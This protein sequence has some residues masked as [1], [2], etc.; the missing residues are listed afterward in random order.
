MLQRMT[1]RPG[2]RTSGRTL[3]VRFRRAGQ[4]ESI[5]NAEHLQQTAGNQVVQRLLRS[6]AIQ[7]KLAV[8][9][10]GDA[11]ECE[12]DRVAGE[13]L[14]MPDPQP[15]PTAQRSPLDIQRKCTK[16]EEKLREQPVSD[17]KEK[18]VHAKWADTS[19]SSGVSGG[20]ESYLNTARGGGQP[21]AARER[22]YFEPRFG[23]EFGNVRVHTNSGAAHA[24]DQIRARA[25]TSGDDIVFGARHYAPE[26]NEG[27]KLL[28]HELSHVVQQTGTAALQRKVDEDSFARLG[29]KIEEVGDRR[30][31]RGHEA[32]ILDRAVIERKIQDHLSS[33][34]FKGDERLEACFD[35]RARLRVGDSGASVEKVQNALIDLGFDLGLAGADG[36]YGPRTAEAVKAFKRQEGLG[37]EQFGDVGPGTMRRLDRIF[38]EETSEPGGDVVTKPLALTGEG[39]GGSGQ[40]FIE[41]PLAPPSALTVPPE[42][43]DCDPPVAVSAF[44]DDVV[45]AGGATTV[46]SGVPC[47]VAPAPPGALSDFELDLRSNPGRISAVVVDPDSQEIIGYRVRTDSTILQ[48]VDREGNFVAGNEKSLDQPLV[49]PIDFIPTPGALAKGAVVVGKIGLKA[50]GKFVAKAG[51]KKGFTVA[52]AAIPRMRRVSQAMLGRARRA[53]SKQLPTIARKITEE[54]LIKTFEDHA[55]EF[56]G[57]SV[58]RTT[59]FELWRQM[60]ERAARS[61]QV[62]PWSVKG[63]NTIAHLATIEGK[64]FVVEFF[65]ET[66]ELATAFVTGPRQLRNMLKVIALTK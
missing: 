23:R 18:I 27:R 24:A 5:A 40:P 12:A 60:I 29:G 52:A 2:F 33:P 7:A 53:A 15:G 21:L 25:F 39:D 17:P 3:P 62:F 42:E 45:A 56:F 34:R 43:G 63:N 9:N 66:G 61:T 22:A 8:S 64:P 26:S 58:R 48:L 35:D 38:P 49:D 1:R 31:V 16:C 13:V 4:T 44:A 14:R 10:P 65:E 55:A 54:R 11:S 6:Q 50:L 41:A 59:H 32:G 28:A 51:G 19:G 37:F 20:L 47:D 46:G 57:R 30:P 36:L